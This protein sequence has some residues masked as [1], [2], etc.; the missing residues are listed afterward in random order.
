[1]TKYTTTQVRRKLE[2]AKSE[3]HVFLGRVRHSVFELRVSLGIWVLSHSTFPGVRACEKCELKAATRLFTCFVGKLLQFLSVHSR[4]F[5]EGFEIDFF[6][7]ASRA[8][9]VL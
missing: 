6:A 5:G 3:D 4:C 1:M 7:D 8:S 2:A 9:A